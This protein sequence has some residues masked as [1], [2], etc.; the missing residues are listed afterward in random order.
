MIQK[1]QNLWLQREEQ[2]ILGVR[3][4]IGQREEEEEVGETDKGEKG[5]L[6]DIL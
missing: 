1:V 2:G 5:D 3:R 6:L 4:H